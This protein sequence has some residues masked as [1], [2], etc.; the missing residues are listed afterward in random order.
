MGVLRVN[1]HLCVMRNMHPIGSTFPSI[2]F[3]VPQVQSLSQCCVR[4]RC[5]ILDSTNHFDGESKIKPCHHIGKQV[6][7]NN[8]RVF[9]GACD[10]VDMELT[11][12]VHLT[13]PESEAV[14]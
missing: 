2:N 8:C 6:V 3:P 14:P 13:A 7:I 5:F 12:T 1:T 11:N 9:I 10:T 4:V